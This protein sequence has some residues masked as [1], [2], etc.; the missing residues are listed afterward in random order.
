MSYFL[1]EKISQLILKETLLREEREK[2]VKN[3]R[4]IFS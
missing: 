4:N 2:D 3:D 1:P